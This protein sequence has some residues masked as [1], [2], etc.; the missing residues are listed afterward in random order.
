MTHSFIYAVVALD[1]ALIWR[2]GLEPRSKPIRLDAKTDNLQYVKERNSRNGD[3]DRSL[4]DHV[5]AEK[6]ASEL[7]GG[8]HIYLL[9]AGSGKSNSAQ[10]LL[11]Y[12]KEK[13]P[14]MAEKVL[15]TGSADVNSLSDNQLLELGRDR[16]LL[17]M[18]T[19]L[20]L[21]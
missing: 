17:F 15:A 3:R 9:S 1:H 20:Q 5:F 14:Q 4:M 12:I 6:I 11:E 21:T 19:N 10:Q 7:Q 16:K 8:S 13:H 2:D 18:R